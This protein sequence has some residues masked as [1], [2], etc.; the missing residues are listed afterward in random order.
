MNCRGCGQTIRY[1]R[2]DEGN[3]WVHAD[4]VWDLWCEK[5]GPEKRM[6]PD[7]VKVVNWSRRRKRNKK[8]WKTTRGRGGGQVVED[9]DEAMALIE[10]AENG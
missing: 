3:E 4:A 1:R 6:D 7:H 8:L 2:G 9:I 10:E 5:A